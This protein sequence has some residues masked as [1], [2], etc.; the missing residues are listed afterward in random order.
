MLAS[1]WA[2]L[3]GEIVLVFMY[4]G[5]FGLMYRDM[6]ALYAT[7][8]AGLA[9]GAALAERRLGAFAAGT[10]VLCAVRLVL[11]AVAAAAWVGLAAESAATTYV[12][13][14]VY[15]LALGVE[16]PVLN[17]LY[18]R[19]EGGEHGAG[20]LHS[21]DH[22]GAA[23]AAVA[24]AMVA[25]PLAGSAAALIGIMAVNAIVLAGWLAMGEFK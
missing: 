4:Q 3:M 17:E 5:R 19:Q 16:Y 20:V 8:M 11:I 23:L 14:F 25:L 21:V 12:M 6:G 15:A 9:V 7:Y 18:R 22:L 13:L 2:G 1:G 24:G 10:W